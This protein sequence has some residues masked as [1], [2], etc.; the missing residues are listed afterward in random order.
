MKEVRI[1]RAPK[2]VFERNYSSFVNSKF[3]DHTDIVKRLRTTDPY[4]ETPNEFVIN[5][6]IIKKINRFLVSSSDHILYRVDDLTYE[7][8]RSILDMVDAGGDG[9]DFHLDYFEDGAVPLDPEEFGEYDLK[10]KFF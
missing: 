9:V 6:T 8:V 5:F 4:G 2:N 1:V 3:M 10:I 7:G